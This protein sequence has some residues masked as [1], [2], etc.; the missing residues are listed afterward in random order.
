M[1]SGVMVDE[2]PRSPKL[3]SVKEFF[4]NRSADKMKKHGDFLKQGDQNY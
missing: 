2:A 4:N 1:V 3:R